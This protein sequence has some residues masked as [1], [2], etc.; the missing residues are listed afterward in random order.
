MSPT[1]EGGGLYC[2]WRGGG[3]PRSLEGGMYKHCSRG[4][5]QRNRRSLR[6]LATLQFYP[7]GRL[8]SFLVS[9]ESLRPSK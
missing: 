7:L 4:R 2:K 1:R 3:Y 5:R 8:P 9:E 6:P